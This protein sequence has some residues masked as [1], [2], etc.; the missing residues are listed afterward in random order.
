M[1]LKCWKKTDKYCIHILSIETD[2]KKNLKNITDFRIYMVCLKS[3]EICLQNGKKKH[4]Y[5]IHI[6][7]VETCRK[8]MRHLHWTKRAILISDV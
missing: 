6:L 3:Y 7:S 4:K 2:R 1:P 5:C 8:K